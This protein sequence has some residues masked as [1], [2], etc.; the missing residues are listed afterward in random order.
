MERPA[1][2]DRGAR[3][4]L[5]TLT[6]VFS[7][8]EGST[9]L[10]Q[11]LGRSY[12]ALLET[13]D[14]IIRT[15]AET[16][17]GHAFGSEGDA[18]HLVFAEVGAA[19]R[20]AL[21]AQQALETQAWPEGVTVRVRMG[22]HSG[23]VR[24]LGDDYVGLALHETARIAAAGHGGQVLL[25]AASAELARDGLPEGI[26]LQDLGE[27][28]LKDLPRPVRLYQL[29]GAGLEATHPPLRTLEAVGARLPTQVTSFVG[30]TEVEAVSRLLASARLVTLTGPGGTGKTRLSIE[31]AAAVAP[32]FEG[33][34]FFVPLDTI[35]DPDLVASEIATA[36]GAVG[37]TEE[38]LD[39]L[40]AHLRDRAVLLV[41][42][43]LEQVVEARSTVSRLLADCPKLTRAGHEP[44]PPERLR[45]ARVPGPHAVPAACR[46]GR[47][48]GRG[49]LGG[50][51]SL[52]RARHGGARR[53]HA[54]RRQCR[55]GGGDRRQAGRPA[56]GHRAGG[57]PTAH[58]A[59][60]GPPGPA[61]RPTRAAHERRA[62][63][64]RAAAHPA[65]RHRVEPRPPGRPRPPP[66]RSL[67]G[68]GRRRDAWSTPSTSVALPRSW[69]ARSSTASTRSPSRACS[70]WPTRRAHPAA[71]CS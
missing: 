42:D 28:R 9:R 21:A 32:R 30:R 46:I 23:E 63:S 19:V 18:Q 50:G 39:R 26:S 38:P 55:G 24:R 6:F 52:R 11:S 68:H 60:R 41:L 45:R 70:R 36:V 20:A 7:D 44:H 48:L 33:G 15:A 57:R 13:H 49:R 22:I 5:G 17:G 40:V 4:P 12:D 3:L 47:G 62:R 35:S 66:L 37:G 51:P 25:S 56:L 61:G 14:R 59:R 64:P 16:E 54:H 67:R 31:V 2:P 1:R 29:A 69:V 10:L 27:H 43:N 71:P 34:A 65:G 8:I 58:P 53:L